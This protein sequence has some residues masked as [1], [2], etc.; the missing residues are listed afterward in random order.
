MGV[1]ERT[2]PLKTLPYRIQDETGKIEAQRGGQESS[3]SST[4]YHIKQ[5]ID[6]CQEVRLALHPPGIAKS[7]QYCKFSLQFVQATVLSRYSV[8]RTKVSFVAS[9]ITTLGTQD[10]R[11]LI[12]HGARVSELHLTRLCRTEP[13]SPALPC[14][15][16]VDAA[17]KRRIL[18]LCGW[19]P[20]I[21]SQ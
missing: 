10:V 16:L 6:H 13:V 2:H 8:S 4:S 17:S 20:F 12:P 1:Q 11:V 7:P 21:P 18:R 14:T 5:K 3:V 15:D 9:H 19:R